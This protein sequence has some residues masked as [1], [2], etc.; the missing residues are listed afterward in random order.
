MGKER[1]KSIDE[2]Q[3]N[4]G[5]PYTNEAVGAENYGTI[6][7]MVESPQEKGVFYTGS[8][9]GLV[10]ITKDNGKTWNNITPKG[11]QQCLINAIEVS[12][13]DA[14]T[15]YIATTRYKFNDYTPAI[16]KTTNYGE[17]WV[18]I[19]ANIPYG[20]FTRV[21]RE[22]P[23]RKNLLY[24]G[25]EGGIYISWDG[26][27]IWE[28]IQLNLPK[29]P[30]TDLK[31]HKDDLIV[32][33]SGRGFWIL[34][35]VTLLSQYNKTK[36][37][38]VLYQPEVT[39]NGNWGSQLSTTNSKFDG[40]SVLSGVNPAFGVVI[41]YELPKL[42]DST[43]VVI[44]ILNSKKEIVRSFS[45]KKDKQLTLGDHKKAGGKMPTSKTNK[46]LCKEM[47]DNASEADV[48]RMPSTIP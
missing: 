38:S 25:T 8:D 23:I 34:D 36:N 2:K 40:S 24:T 6:S 45:S 47:Y 11:I 30:I 28:S 41:Y 16:Y 35:D 48:L 37:S 46:I 13:H 4:G 39:Y 33:T 20:S 12:P 10:H 3:G 21:V 43:E 9:D 18:N 5:G 31:L 29:T 22:D 27:K 32:S 44:E 15:A 42:A 26:G 19:S 17:S 7:Y 1:S 14:A